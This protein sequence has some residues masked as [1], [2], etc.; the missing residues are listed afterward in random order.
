MDLKEKLAGLVERFIKAKEEGKLDYA[1]EETIRTWI[2]EL[3]SLFG[4]D[5][6]NTHQVLQERTLEKDKRDKLRGIG[7]TNVRP[8][9]TL[10]NGSV[11]LSFI[12]A[13][14]L[15]VNIAE[16][17]ESS[18]QIRSYGWSIGA[19]FSIVTNFE[20]FA[21]YECSIMPHI[22]D[23]SNV[24]RVALYSCKEYVDNLEMM[25]F[26]LDRGKVI[27][28]QLDSIPH[29]EETLDQRFSKSLSEIR[30]KL[31]ESILHE[32]DGINENQIN[33]YVQIIL[34]RI[35]F[36]RVC[37]AR[38]MEEDGLLNKFAES[39]FWKNFRESSYLNFYNHYDGP[40]FSR[41]AELQGLSIDN[42][43]FK[44]LLNYLYYPSP[45]RFDV[46]PLKTL[47]DMYDTF[48]GYKL[49][50]RNGMIVNELK[51]EYK[52]SNGAVT[53]PEHIVNK[54]I[55]STMPEEIL[56]DMSID[57]IMNLD[58]VDPACGSGAFLVGAYNHISDIV[59]KKV[60]DGESV[61]RS[62]IL[63][64]KSNNPILTIKG[65][66]T[67]INNCIHGVDINPEAVEVARMSLSLKILDGYTPEQFETAGFLGSKILNGVGENVRCGNSLVS[68]DIL[69]IVPSIADKL[70]EYESTNV[71]SWNDAFPKVFKKGGFDF[72][73]GNPPYIEVRNYNAGLPSMAKYI[74]N[75]YYSCKKDKVDLAI[76]FIE[77][78]ISLLNDKG[79]MGYIVQ[80]RFFKTDYGEALRKGISENKQLLKIHDYAEND[81]FSGVI[82]YVAII[83]CGHNNS[84]FVEFSDSKGEKID[85]PQE[86]LNGS[87][88]NLGNP[89][90][91]QLTDRLARKHGVLGSVCSVN[92]GIQVL[93]R[94]AYQVKVS[95][96]K[97]GFIHGGTKLDNNVILEEAACR[98]LLCNEKIES[99]CQPELKTYVL[100]P[101]H[102]STK[103]KATRI[104]FSEYKRLYPKAGE[105][106]AKYK[107][108]IL[109]NVQTQPERVKGL[110]KDEYWHIYTRE[111][112]LCDEGRKVCVP[113]TSKE[114]VA[115]CLKDNKVYCDN[116]NMFYLRFDNEAT[117]RMY[118]VAAIINSTPFATMA[119]M[120]AN[121]QQ[122]GYFKFS[123]QFLTPVPFPCQ[124]FR[125]NS[126]EIKELAD[127]GRSISE[128]KDRISSTNAG[129]NNRFSS[130][131]R[132]KYSRIDEICRTMYGVKDDEY[133]LLMSNKREDRI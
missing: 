97:D 128:I 103:S 70:D 84:G 26:F 30:V 79:R 59:L 7:S 105:Y 116:A 102:I 43:V 80:K 51:P 117:D 71:F 98:A 60:A 25:S 27:S 99:F 76:P 91:L 52:K 36:I 47:S 108:T 44:Q 64:D 119:K 49:A 38:G 88:W 16:S 46:I 9:Y 129:A 77:K 62:L 55:D 48:L 37:E 12:D 69:D 120:F 23:E 58:I 33:S 28:R 24:C 34:N 63:F 8:D 122:N 42:E 53:T 68:S 132:H 125:D 29:A 6:Q 17:K 89:D 65:R 10:A 107:S 73:V 100:F 113:M 75:K 21:V 4:W 96:I 104:P 22:S 40:M 127:L 41:I 130:L 82:T 87:S 110:D 95:Y 86:C 93:W 78:G 3:L 92:V 50:I 126:P 31:A 106:L 20:Q 1:S 56:D 67:L 11:P 15:D 45:Y 90:L 61:D 2:N 5:V 32:N 54:V 72:V 14:S 133:R 114:P 118:A 112:H 19:M 74:K 123:K 57:D 18:F 66:K 94:D 124:A 111:S 83:V 85:I 81:L 101:Y 13:K 39:D 109:S 131:L 121:P 35:L 115:T